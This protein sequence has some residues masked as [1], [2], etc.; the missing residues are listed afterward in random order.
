MALQPLLNRVL[1][2]Y[3]KRLNCASI[4]ILKVRSDQTTQSIEVEKLFSLPKY[5]ELD[6]SYKAAYG[7]VDDLV[8]NG[9]AIDGVVSVMT[10]E[11]PEVC[12][13]LFGLPKFGVLIIKVR[14]GV[15][16]NYALHSIQQV[17]QKLTYMCL[18]CQ[19]REDL[20]DAKQSAEAATRAKSEFL[21]NMSHEIRT[22]MNAI[23][24]MGGMLLDTTLS[25]EQRE[26]AK[27]IENSANSLLTIINDILDFSKIEAGKLDLEYSD[28]D[29]YDAMDTI[30][31]IV[32]FGIVDKDINLAY[33][34]APDV[35]THVRGDLGRFR[36]VLINLVNN[37]I[38]FT[39]HGEVIVLGELESESDTRTVLRFSVVDTGIGMEAS[40]TD[41]LFNTFSQLD[42]SNHRKFGGTGLGLVICKAL[43][44][45]MGGEIGFQSQLGK[46]SSFWFTI[47]FHKPAGSSLDSRDKMINLNG[48]RVMV[49]D[50]DDINRRVFRSFLQRWGADVVEVDNGV[51]LLTMMLQMATDEEPI[52]IVFIDVRLKGI[53]C[54]ALA[55]IINNTP[56]LSAAKRIMVGSIGLRLQLE[57][58]QSLGFD[59]F[60]QTPI[61][62]FKLIDCMA[63]IL[64]QE[65]IE[66]NDAEPDRSYI[67]RRVTDLPTRQVCVL[68]ADDNNV[69]QLVMKKM[70][71][72][73][74]IQVDCVDNGQQAVQA[75]TKKE[76]DLVFMDYQMPV[77]DGLE[78]TRSIRALAGSRGEVP[79][80]AVTANVL[81][82]FEARCQEASMNG[83]LSKPV[84]I[85][86]LSSALDQW[87]KR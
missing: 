78:A 55:K 29:L 63:L 8:V 58:V 19:Q 31:D 9:E 48:R 11:Q 32:S 56:K 3:V 24:G 59:R 16:N 87:I 71:E 34:L 47:V 67:S 40:E 33:Y 68:V 35:T 23:I 12:S 38:K 4:S 20:I 82:D 54:N 52:D 81:R 69:N 18:G 14:A 64:E 60:I 44:K 25:L 13:Y 28:F 83:Y 75:V 6:P 76:Y 37:A 10:Q 30:V 39:E 66:S 77:M 21:A 85:D 42:N 7:R 51:D 46:G 43:V 65:D 53:G 41:R 17:N 5:I 36:Q 22:P 45:L 73:K 74:G 50:S 70:L 26:C 27:T 86:K 80:V 1:R 62:K 49:G 79:V 61:K 84:R 72:K 2:V 57:S 15:F